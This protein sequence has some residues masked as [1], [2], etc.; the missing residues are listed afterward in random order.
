MK[1]PQHRI[2]I[3]RKRVAP[4]QQHGGAWKIAYAD[5]MTAM[6]AFFLVMWLLALIPQK[7]L[8]EIAEYFRMPLMTA[9]KGGPHVD[10]ARNVIPGGEPSV[11][12]NI[13]PMPPKPSRNVED[14]ADRADTLRLEDLKSQ[15]ESLI[16]VDPVLKEFRPQLLLD[17]TPDGLRVQIID[18]QNRPMFST[19]SAHVQPYM[20]DILRRL[21]PL[22]NEMPNSISVSGHTDSTQYAKGERAYSNWELSADRANAARQEL[23]AG[24]M[25]EPRIKQVLGLSS[26]VSLIKD[27]PQAAVNRRISIVVLNRR[28]ERRIDAQ[29]NAGTSDI[30]LETLMQSSDSSD[31]SGAT[32]NPQP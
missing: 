23:V 10:N 32:G 26:T 31:V 7:D 6:M 9:I 1:N 5:F 12:P 25:S 11:V 16:R 17:M 8:Q 27:D 19:G 21:G 22:F 24:G 15:L 3:R 30:D 13:Q 29:N 14:A 2:V 20:R 4:V 18:R 28:A